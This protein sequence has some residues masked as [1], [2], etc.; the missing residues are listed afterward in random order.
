M[1]IRPATRHDIPG[2]LRFIRELAEYERA[3]HEVVA[4]EDSLREHLFDG[5]SG[6]RPTAEA[7]IGE[8]DGQPRG[9]AL[10]FTNFSTWLGRPGIYLED[11]YVT[12]VARGRGLGRA[13]LTRLAQIAVERGAGRL[14]WAVL[15]WN[16]PAIEFYRRLGARPLDE[17]LPF[18][19]SGDALARLAQDGR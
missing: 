12:P 5:A 9:F 7:L 17:W 10:F 3:P 4:T 19:L 8:I 15:N 11:L 1:T 18:R 2:I 16:T 6:G 13:L 14:D